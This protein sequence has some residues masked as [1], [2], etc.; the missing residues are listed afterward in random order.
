MAS[1][2]WNNGHEVRV[3]CSPRGFVC[4][5]SLHRLSEELR[6]WQCLQLCNNK[7]SCLVIRGF[8]MRWINRHPSLFCPTWTHEHLQHAHIV[9]VCHQ[10]A[11]CLTVAPSLKGVCR[12]FLACTLASGCSSQFQALLPCREFSLCYF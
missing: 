9:C 10:C 1:A 8:Y 7:H 4:L 2:D 11:F 6:N 12:R 5:L 3:K